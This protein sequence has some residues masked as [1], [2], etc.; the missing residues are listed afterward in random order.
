MGRVN[1]TRPSDYPR[2]TGSSMQR[3]TAAKPSTVQTPTGDRFGAIHD[4]KAE[5]DTVGSVRSQ[6]ADRGEA[7]QRRRARR[8]ALLLMILSGV[9]VIAIIG[10]TWLVLHG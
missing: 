6:D 3:L 10:G 2:E 1:W 9:F 8:L 4:T 7:M 5:I